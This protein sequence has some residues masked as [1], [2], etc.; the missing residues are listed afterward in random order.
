MESQVSLQLARASAWFSQANVPLLA[1]SNNRTQ[2]EKGC[3]AKKLPPNCGE[4]FRREGRT[5][6]NL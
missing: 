4:Q 1:L 5:L 6:Q 2:P 3:Q